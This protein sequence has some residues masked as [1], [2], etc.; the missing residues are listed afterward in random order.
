WQT[1]AVRT[2]CVSLL[3]AGLCV[4]WAASKDDWWE[5]PSK[6]LAALG[7]G[8]YYAIAGIQLTLVLLAA[9]AYTAGAI[10]LDK[11]RGI[12]AHLLVTDLSN[13]EIILSKL[14]PR[15][16]VVFGLIFATLPVLAL[17]TFMGGIDPDAL[18]GLLAVSL[19]VALLGCTLT[20][21]LSVWSR[22]TH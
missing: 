21:M 5:P 22:K 17:G 15:V 14:G 11:A 20:V 16:L 12:L 6:R 4:A 19:G 9:P 2:L 10:S 8:F 3:L 18:V 7:E 1:Y 13:T